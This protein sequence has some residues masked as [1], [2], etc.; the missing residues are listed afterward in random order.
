MWRRVDLPEPEGPMIARCSPA[1]ISSWTSTRACTGSPPTSKVREMPS[2]RT[3]RSPTLAPPALLRAGL[4]PGL[5]LGAVEGDD[6]ARPRLEASRH[7][8]EVPV[9]Q[10]H[11]ELHLGQPPAV[12]D[13]DLA[14]LEQGGGGHPQDA[15][16]RAQ[17]D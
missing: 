13:E 4:H 2:R 3:M 16:A 17:D 6:H 12:E 14:P 15:V 9:P 1:S 5:D 7:L 11:L 10:P 8:G